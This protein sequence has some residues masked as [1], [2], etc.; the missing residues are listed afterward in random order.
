M[1]NVQ[2]VCHL[3]KK[4]VYRIKNKR[5]TVRTGVCMGDLGFISEHDK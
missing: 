2:K 1:D 5:Y 4:E 3:T